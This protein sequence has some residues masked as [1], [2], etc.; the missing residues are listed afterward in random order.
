[1]APIQ[2]SEAIQ[3]FKKLLEENNR[4]GQAADLSALMWYMDGMTRQYEAMPWK[5]WKIKSKP[6]RRGWLRWRES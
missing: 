2:D 3:Q 4:E 6:M 5:V 1:M